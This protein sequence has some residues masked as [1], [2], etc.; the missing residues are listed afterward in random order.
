MSNLVKVGQIPLVNEVNPSESTQLGQLDRVNLEFVC[1][2]YSGD[3]L[4][5]HEASQVDHH[6]GGLPCTYGI[7][8]VRRTYPRKPKIHLKS[9]IA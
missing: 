9:L 6:L 4:G 8:Q 5:V 2:A 3:M 1:G 7:L